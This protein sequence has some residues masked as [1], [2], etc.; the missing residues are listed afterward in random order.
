MTPGTGARAADG[1]PGGAT[2]SRFELFRDAWGVPHVR[3]VT[4]L[5][6]S[7]GQ[8]YAAGLDRGWQVLV[9]RW[10]VE[11]RFAAR[12]GA[13][14]LAWD[15]FAV[16]VRLRD[17]VLRVW[18]ALPPA[19]RRW[20]AAHAAGVR[21]GL[22]S[23]GS[24]APEIDRLRGALGGAPL[25]D[26]DAWPEWM[27]VGVFLLNHVLFSGFA[28]LLWREHALRTLGDDARAL[29][30]L[31]AD[32][33]PSSGS[34]AWALHGSRTASG[35][36]L[37]AGDPHRLL[38][39]PGVYQ[40]VRLAC[41]GPDGAFDVL[42][43]AFP[44]V[45]GVPHFGQTSGRAGSAAWGIT[46]ALAHHV[47]LFTEDLPG[48][49]T[50][51][52]ADLV[53]VRGGE[54]VPVVWTE[55]PRGPVVTDRH[56]VRWPVRV[57]A[58]AGVA[59]WRRL[60]HAVTA[61]DV[62]AAFAG[63]VDPVHRVLAAD[64]GGSVVSLTAGLVPDVA[65]AD[66]ERPRPAPAVAPPWRPP[67]A[68]VQVADV[69]V[70]ANERPRDPAAD[71]GYAY[72]EHR[73]DRIR[74][75][76][77]QASGGT[78]G[79]A[80]PRAQE[81]ILGD[82]QDA[83]AA[84]LVGWLDAEAEPD[85]APDDEAGRLADRLRAWAAAG[86]RM[87]AESTDAAVFARWRHALVR[88]M[89]AHPALAPLHADPALPAIFAPW[90]DVTARV[91][92]VLPRLLAAADG[93]VVGGHRLDAR[94]EAAAAFAEVVASLRRETGDRTGDGPDGE[95]DPFS[96]AAATWG[97]L[98]RLHPL[99]ALGEL[100]GADAQGVVVPDVPAVALG[101]AGDTVR[102]TGGVPGVT[103]LASRGSVAR[104][105]WDLGDRRRSRWGVPFGA[106]GDP[107]SPHFADQ[108]ELWAQ[109]RTTAIETDWARLRPEHPQEDR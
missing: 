22:A 88:R 15:R 74:A 23:G 53:P 38:E 97:D 99:H 52:G 71:L 106:S 50:A 31:G 67:A 87:D 26:D 104:W 19:E 98:H 105:V 17:T 82:T 14:G 102:C 109:A 78:A 89:A 100:A 62:A 32:G 30:L 66:R 28:H 6:V 73:A 59:A 18:D 60:Q 12:F 36:P 85:D 55:T 61:D 58:D 37:L 1:V 76:L 64:S 8:G 13:A 83:G 7:F 51:S 33:G 11:G 44:G 39:L 2:G 25:P 81:R 48:Q 57:R 70:D 95:G 69:A 10:Q 9:A 16:R 86:A 47:E 43:L 92:D 107:G 101:G 49:V 29:G 80:T 45:P 27:P 3:G 42:G 56:S 68:V 77:A 63:W 103:F 41:T 94:A 90:L 75:L 21:A 93:R 72:A 35:L 54:P 40:Q 84:A 5:D 34:N 20:V 96:G 24:D 79:G 91:S 4:E 65:R 46:N 108:H